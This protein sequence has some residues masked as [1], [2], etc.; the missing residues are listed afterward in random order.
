MKSA[1]RVPGSPGAGKQV[2]SFVSSLVN[3]VDNI[4]C[5]YKAHVATGKTQNELAELQQVGVGN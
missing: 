5:W 1:P 4:T 3:A 2:F